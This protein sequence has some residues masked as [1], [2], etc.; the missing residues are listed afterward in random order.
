MVKFQILTPTSAGPSVETTRSRAAW[1]GQAVWMKNSLCIRTDA[2]ATKQGSWGQS[3][4]WA[5]GRLAR[6]LIQAVCK[7]DFW[8]VSKKKRKKKKA[9]SL[10]FTL[11]NISV[12]CLA[13][14]IH[15]FFFFVPIGKT[16]HNSAHSSSQTSRLPSGSSSEFLFHKFV[17]KKK[18][19]GSYWFLKSKLPLSVQLSGSVVSNS[20]RPYGLQHTRPPLS[21]TNSWSLLKLMSIDFFSRVTDFKILL[22]V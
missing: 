12:N 4:S 15:S 6:I 2:V 7:H 20:L 14:S 10:F 13:C 8:A 22:K 19:F 9:C 5:D 3:G 18:I 17:R 1:D 16:Q 11:F 21:I